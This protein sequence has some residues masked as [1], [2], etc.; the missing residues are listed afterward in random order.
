LPSSNWEKVDGL[1]FVD[2]EIVDDKNMPGDTLGVRRI[3]S[4]H[5]NM[6]PLKKQL[7]NHQGILKQSTRYFI[8][9]NGVPFIY[10]KTLMCKL[11][12]YKIKKIQKKEV[13][14]VL[15][16]KGINSPF[17]IPRPP[18][19]GMLWAGVLHYHGLPWFLYEYSETK[20]PDTRRKV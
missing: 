17:T 13:A 20:K 16:L 3:Q 2:N 11:S 18:E 19:D 14:S 10:E 9:S 8:D 5:K 6:L 12:Y 15:W 7:I 4:P 1:L